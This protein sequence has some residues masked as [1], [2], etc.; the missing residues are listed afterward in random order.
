MNDAD[1]VSALK[2][3]GLTTYEARAFVGLQK[4]GAGTASE[5]ADVADVPRSQV[6]GAAEDLEGR[7]LVEV[8]Q[9]N[10]TR[11]RPVGVDEARDRLYRQLESEGDTAFDYL[12]SVREEYGA[13]EETES[14]WTVRGT[15]NVVARAVRL[16]ASAE[17][18][19]VYGTDDID[20]FEASLQDALAD[21]VDRGVDVTTLSENPAVLD[22]ISDVGARTVD[23]PQ[24]PKPEIGA[25]RVLMVDDDTVL[26]SIVGDEG[27]ETAF[28]S[29]GTAFASML[30]TLLSEFVADAVDRET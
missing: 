29:G 22:A 18:T 19:A 2:R 7:G 13:S 16:L 24:P 12:E 14:I 27:A 6:Y 23:V 11:Y 4:L 28:W 1:A 21:A 26:V 15:S 17:S 8:E 10:P 5:V 9:S 3:L 20:R 30:T 25:T